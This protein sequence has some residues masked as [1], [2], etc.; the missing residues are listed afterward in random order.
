MLL[1]RRHIILILL[2]LPAIIFSQSTKLEKAL[3]KRFEVKR[4]ILLLQDSLK[5]IENEISNLQS[6]EFESFL[7]KTDEIYIYN[8]RPTTKLRK[9]AWPS[10][11]VIKEFDQFVNVILLGFEDDYL[12]VNTPYGIGYV[13]RTY[14]VQGRRKNSRDNN[15]S[16]LN[17][18]SLVKTKSFTN[19]T[20]SKST[21]TRPSRKYTRTRR[22]IRGPR[23]GCYYINSNG[24]KT[25]VARS[26]CN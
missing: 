9:T 4:E 5:R 23:G 24:N 26:L 19:S 12:K 7:Q 11:E 10:S 14:A 20:K 21:T 22:Y 16:N 15:E 1:G 17:S 13:H 8:C 3:L 25:Y 18:N 2:C 6:L